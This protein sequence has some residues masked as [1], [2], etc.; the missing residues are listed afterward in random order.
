MSKSHKNLP[1]SYGATNASVSQSNASGSKGGEKWK[2]YRKLKV[3]DIENASFGSNK[4]SNQYEQ[5]IYILNKLESKA[6]MTGLLKETCSQIKKLAETIKVEIPKYREM[7]TGERLED[8]GEDLDET[9]AEINEE[10]EGQKTR[11]KTLGDGVQVDK[12]FVIKLFPLMESILYTLF[13][14]IQLIILGEDDPIQ[15]TVMMILA[16]IDVLPKI[17]TDL[18]TL[19]SPLEEI[20]FW[21]S[22]HQANISEK[23]VKAD[24]KEIVE[25]LVKT[26]T[27][28]KESGKHEELGI[29]DDVDQLLE[30]I[31]QNQEEAKKP[32]EIL[33]EER[34]KELLSTLRNPIAD[35]VDQYLCSLDPKLLILDEGEDRDDF[36]IVKKGSAMIDGGLSHVLSKFVDFRSNLLATSRRELQTEL[37][38]LATLSDENLTNFIGTCYKDNDLVLVWEYQKT[39]LFD[40]LFEQDGESIQPIYFRSAKS[41]GKEFNNER[42][43][44]YARDI[45]SGLEYL[46]RNGVVHQNL[47]TK[48]IFICNDFETA[49][50]GDFCFVDGRREVRRKRIDN[51]TEERDSV[52]FTITYRAP[53]TINRSK[54]HE[55][56]ISVFA[57]DMYSFGVILFELLDQ[58]KAYEGLTFNNFF[59][60]L[61][62]KIPR[63][64]NLSNDNLTKV[65]KLVKDILNRCWQQKPELRPTASA[66]L[67]ELN[68]QLTDTSAEEGEEEPIEEG[69]G[70]ENANRKRDPSFVAWLSKVFEKEE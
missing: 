26:L 47:T 67:N 56:P 7:L 16:G 18:K 12:N 29:A 42:L 10:N 8:E 66:V 68:F 69:E 38:K 62:A 46:H 23:A 35:S 36:G 28:M 31:T 51:L 30:A 2:P 44:K 58:V 32:A 65:P 3:L 43:M 64:P 39:I 70:D 21:E 60:R 55:I 57:S 37:E 40:L 22:K 50:I 24:K 53:E 5:V 59:K 17:F 9:L 41:G 61:Y 49:K 15:V 11:K 4:Y 45:A 48:S 33:E 14:H 27:D 19:V 52:E 54:T 34:I 13:R 20:E 25:L 1:T 63:R 6:A